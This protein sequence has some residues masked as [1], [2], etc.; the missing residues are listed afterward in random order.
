[1]PIEITITKAPRSANY[2]KP[3][4]VFNEA[5]GTIG[6]SADNTWALDDPNRYMSSRHA[7]IRHENGQYYLVDTSTNGTFHNGANEPLGSGTRVALKD[8]DRF[9]LSDYEFLVTFR[10]GGAS[11]ASSNDPYGA[12]PFGGPSA[13]PFAQDVGAAARSHDD[14]FA[15][16][17]D[18]PLHDAATPLGPIHE[19][20]DPLAALD[21]SNRFGSSAAPVHFEF[22]S[23][24]G[25]S[26]DPLSQ[27]VSWPSAIP[28]DWDSDDLAAAEVPASF[29]RSIPIKPKA[30]EAAGGSAELLD[31]LIHSEEARKA[32]EEENQ[33]LLADIV[34]LR[35]Q[36]K[37]QQGQ[38]A[39][40]AAA[41]SLSSLDKELVEAMGLNV[42]SMSEQ[43]M[44]EITRMSGELIREAVA[45]L[46]QVL[47]FRKRI[48]EEFRINVTTIQ[49]VENNPLKFSA[50]LEDALENM[51]LKDNRAYQKPIEAVRESFQGIA[52]HQVAVLA[53][54][55][56]AFRGMIERMDPEALEK[57]F[58]KYRGGGVLKV[59]QKGRNWDAYKEYHQDLVD[60]MDNSFQHLFGY[61]F[62]QA[63]ENQMQKLMISRKAARTDKSNS[64]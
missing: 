11:F 12:D 13:L 49:P 5:G 18:T 50:N 28:E 26:V 43:K 60:N 21:R 16:P 63:Y 45:G 36:L 61:D 47:S 17:F 19:E 40:S 58:E 38:S 31:R 25:D 9:S 10:E 51:F 46:M 39:Q 14:P 23:T 30:A 62:V 35:Q 57:R 29:S 20:T 34:A 27:A 44:L 41:R 64:N 24:Q 6:R 53:G 15:E 7:E 3:S 4:H 42:D 54:I 55:Q 56:A 48:K 52:E 8:G 59:G 32:L 22:R 33:R 37:A 2:S 1:M